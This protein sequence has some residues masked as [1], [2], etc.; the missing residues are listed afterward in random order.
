MAGRDS[1]DLEGEVQAKAG[2]RCVRCPCGALL[3][4]EPGPGFRIR[5]ENETAHHHELE[6]PGCYFCISCLIQ[7]N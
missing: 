7:F 1:K 3:Q 4:A 5:M 2:K 6:E